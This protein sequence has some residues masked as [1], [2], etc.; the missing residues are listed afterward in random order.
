M[1][2]KCKADFT[3]KK[4]CTGHAGYWNFV[5]APFVLFWRSLTIFCFPCLHVYFWRLVQPLQKLLPCFKFPYEDPDFFGAKALGDHDDE[6]VG[7]C[8]SSLALLC[9]LATHFLANAGKG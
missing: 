6:T 8:F 4:I 7:S 2:D 5:C 9:C 3:A 1:M